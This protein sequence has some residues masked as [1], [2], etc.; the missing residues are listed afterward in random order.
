MEQD[1]RLSQVE[2]VLAKESEDGSRDQIHETSEVLKV[3]PGFMAVGFLDEIYT[4]A[5]LIT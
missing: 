2:R 1:E 3:A 5:E 4:A